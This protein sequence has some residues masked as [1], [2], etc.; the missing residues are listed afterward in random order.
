MCNFVVYKAKNIA[1]IKQKLQKMNLNFPGVS[2]VSE[3]P[4]HYILLCRSLLS[5]IK[6]YR[7]NGI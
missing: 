3:T 4:E 2:S 7:K 6:D 1:K 5:W